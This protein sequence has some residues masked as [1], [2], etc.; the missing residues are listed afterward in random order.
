MSYKLRLRP[1]LLTAATTAATVGTAA[2]AD[3]AR[4]LEAKAR[5]ASGGWIISVTLKHG[6]TGWE[7][8]ADGWRILDPGGKELGLRVL[9]HPHVEEQPFTRSLAAVAIPAGTA[10]VMIQ[11]RTSQ[12]GWGAQ[13][14]KLELP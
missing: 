7:D 1:A 3:D 13:K 9:H 11:A 5:Q 8:Y 12:D 2:F 6:D 4:I 14:F 10:H